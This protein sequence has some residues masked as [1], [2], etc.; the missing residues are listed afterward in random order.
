ML[1][2]L[3]KE[4]DE[5]VLLVKRAL[6][7]AGDEL[8]MSRV[9][10]LGGETTEQKVAKLREFNEKLESLR[11]QIDELK[12]ARDTAR[13]HVETPVESAETK[14]ASPRP[15][16]LGSLVISH[17]EFK[18]RAPNGL[19]SLDIDIDI[20]ALLSTGGFPPE[21]TR[22][23][24]IAEAPYRPLELLDLFPVTTTTQAAVQ[25]MAENLH[26]NAAAEKDEG[27]AFPE[28][29][30]SYVEVT[31]PVRKIAVWLPVT[32]EVL[33]DEP[34]VQSLVNTRLAYFL[35]ER[36][37]SQVMVGDG[38]APNLRGVLSRTGIQSITGTTTA[39]LLDKIL[40]GIVAVSE[41]GRANP[42]AIVVSYAAWQAIAG[43]KSSDGVYLFG[44]PAGA[45]IT[46]L[47][48]LPLVP[49]SVLPTAPN[50]VYAVVGSFRGFSEIAVRQGVTVEV[51]YIND[52]FIKGRQAIRGTVRA[53]L[54][55]YR[56][57]AFA[58]VRSGS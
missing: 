16:D 47:W 5:I 31:E 32:D 1:Y 3:Q 46:R 15:R 17:P 24:A 11:K 54:V 44:S 53:A 26:A 6:E 51:G 58:V 19:T 21:V 14:S 37:D 4:Y 20:K 30:I 13:K 33:A 25:Y 2:Q 28:A 55:V 38:T 8:D 7:E 29:T 27:A 22:T 45:P 34:R 10:V 18:R 43:A 40:A 23:G 35:R 49:T 52:D 50:I 12:S 41:T 39:N 36:L 56:P 57:S 42:D 48:G 9:T